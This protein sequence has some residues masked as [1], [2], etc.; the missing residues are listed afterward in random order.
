MCSSLDEEK[1]LSLLSK[2]CEAYLRSSENVLVSSGEL[3]KELSRHITLP[4]DGSDELSKM[5]T[6]IQIKL[7]DWFQ[8]VMTL[9]PLL[10]PLLS[11]G[12]SVFPRLWPS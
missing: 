10:L 5:A 7:Y 4:C 2:L 12:I 8:Q 3:A 9:S 6:Q 11:L 1:R